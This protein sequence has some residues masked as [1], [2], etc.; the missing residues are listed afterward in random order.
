MR[1]GQKK[2]VLYFQ[3]KKKGMALN[4]TNATTIAKVYGDDTE[5]WSGMPIILFEA[6]VD[7]QGETRPAVR[8]SVDRQPQQNS[9]APPRQPTQQPAYADREPPPHQTIP[10]HVN[11]AV[12]GYTQQGRPPMADEEIPF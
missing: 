1:D 8:V 12:G 3:G 10:A 11:Q 6:M 5:S 7:F 2:P 4:K 9:Q